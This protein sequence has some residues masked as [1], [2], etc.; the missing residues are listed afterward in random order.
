MEYGFKKEILLIKPS[1]TLSST[2][3]FKKSHITLLFK[4]KGAI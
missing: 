2:Q 1:G 3:L 4:T